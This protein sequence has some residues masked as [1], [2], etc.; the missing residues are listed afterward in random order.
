MRI[1]Q[2]GTYDRGGGAE[3][4]AWQ[5]LEEYRRRGHKAML[6]VGEKRGTDP[7]VFL[8]SG[9]GAHGKWEQLCDQLA[10]Q[11]QP[12]EGKVRGVWQLRKALHTWVASPKQWHDLYLGKE[13]FDFPDPWR[14]L[15][16]RQGRRDDGRLPDGGSGGQLEHQLGQLETRGRAVRLRQA[17][18]AA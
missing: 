1:L 11:L 7:D 15:D 6:A 18:T 4:V 12:F 17:G 14:L 16:S 3:A 10:R 5:L 2:V 8:I 9:R 13:S